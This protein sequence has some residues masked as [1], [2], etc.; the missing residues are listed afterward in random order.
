MLTDASDA[1]DLGCLMGDCATGRTLGE[2]DL[3]V[4]RVDDLVVGV[5]SEVGVDVTVVGVA[6]LLVALG[7]RSRNGSSRITV[8]TSFASSSNA[9][10]ESVVFRCVVV[11]DDFSSDLEAPSALLGGRCFSMSDRD[12]VVFASALHAL[13]FVV[14]PC[15]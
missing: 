8:V 9:Y 13:L 1:S 10:G 7:C 11:T 15:P 2:D 4:V 5:C 12:E 6:G 3:T 14:L